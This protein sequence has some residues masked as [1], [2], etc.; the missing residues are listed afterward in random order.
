MDWLAG[1]EVG[2]VALAAAVFHFLFSK[3]WRGNEMPRAAARWMTAGFVMACLALIRLSDKGARI[4]FRSIFPLL[5]FL[6]AWAYCVVA[7]FRPRGKP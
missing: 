3:K 1:V 4:D 5:V 7:W 6:T 2:I